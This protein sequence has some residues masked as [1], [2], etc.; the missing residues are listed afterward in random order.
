MKV[1]TMYPSKWFDAEEH[2]DEGKRTVTIAAVYLY[3]A[4]V[5]M[6]GSPARTQS[7]KPR[8]AEVK[9]PLYVI[10]FQ[11]EA[12]PCKLKKPMAAAI[13]GLLGSDDTDDWIG[14][15]ITIFPI[16]VQAWG[17]TMWVWAV[18]V[19]R[20]PSPRKGLSAATADMRPIGETAA[21][22]FLQLAQAK[23]ATQEHFHRFLKL[24][25]PG[26]LELAF[27]VEPKDWPAALLPSCKQFLDL[28]NHPGFSVDEAIKAGPTA[29]QETATRPPNNLAM[30]GGNLTNTTTG[31]VVAPGRSNVTISRAPV[32]TINEADIPF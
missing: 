18:D 14:E 25:V 5:Q 22:R 29:L 21:T 26:G 7:G 2:R 10:E 20:P 9:E 24:H 23:A 17:E 8:Q 15:T 31:E 6:N 3:Q 32:P 12:K 11:E 30:V 1:G 4:N 27:G 19:V 13:E 16:Q 28:I